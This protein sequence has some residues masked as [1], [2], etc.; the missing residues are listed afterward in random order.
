MHYVN[1]RTTAI[2]MQNGKNHRTFLETALG[3]IGPLRS[4]YTSQLIRSRFHLVRIVVMYAVAIPMLVASAIYLHNL[5]T[6]VYV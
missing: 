5:Y 1:M 2:N 6:N 3:W 4:D